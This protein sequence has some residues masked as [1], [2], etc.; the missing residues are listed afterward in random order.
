MRSVR[1]IELV[2]RARFAGA[3]RGRTAGPDQLGAGRAHAGG[4]RRGP[5]D[6][7]VHLVVVLGVMVIG[8]VGAGEVSAAG[9]ASVSVAVT[10]GHPGTMDAVSCVSG[11]F[12][13]AVGSFAE[14]WNGQRWSIQAGSTGGAWSS[15]DGSNGLGGAP[16]GAGVSCTSR[17]FCVAVGLSADDQPL[18]ELWNGRKWSQQRLPQ[19]SDIGF[20]EAGLSG[21]SCASKSDCIAVGT[22][23]SC[24]SDSC[25]VYAIVY[26]WNGRRWSDRDGDQIVTPPSWADTGFSSVSCTSATACTAVGGFDRGFCESSVFGGSPCFPLVER[27]DGHRWSLQRIYNRGGERSAGPSGVSCAS[28]TSCTAVGRFGGGLHAE[29]WNGS[30]WASRRIATPAGATNVALNGVSCT[31]ASHCIAVGSFAA[32][33]GAEKLLAERLDGSTGSLLAVA[34]PPGATGGALNGVSCTSRTSC[35]AVGS[36]KVAGQPLPLTLIERLRR[37]GGFRQQQT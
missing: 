36:F 12:C 18:G 21:V 8:L 3:C 10:S 7:V 13:T 31:S 14:G 22:D 37:S 27:W 2:C 5:A 20:G 9:G 34:M 15:A 23:S 16:P 33:S 26:R 24:G 30:H 29:R 35:I 19:R 1:V 4:G 28:G 17:A 11:G 25:N 32:S 6:G